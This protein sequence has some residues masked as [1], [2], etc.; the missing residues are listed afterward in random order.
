MVPMEEGLRET[1]RW[2]QSQQRPAADYS[3]EDPILAK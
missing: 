2:Y 3:S 1:F